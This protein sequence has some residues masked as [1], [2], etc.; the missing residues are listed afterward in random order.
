V[1]GT[2]D[3]RQS[4]TRTTSTYY[5]SDEYDNVD[6][7]LLV[8]V[9]SFPTRFLLENSFGQLHEFHFAILSSTVRDLLPIEV[10]YL[11]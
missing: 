10:V 2:T 9:R 6:T 3:D 1:A 11:F 4:V 8:E 7:K 5:I